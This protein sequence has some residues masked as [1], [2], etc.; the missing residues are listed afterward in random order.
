MWQNILVGLVTSVVLYFTIVNWDKIVDEIAFWARQNNLSGV[1]NVLCT[2]ENIRA[3]FRQL[4]FKLIG[5]NSNDYPEIITK[6]NI[7]IEDLPS[8]FQYIGTKQH[9]ITI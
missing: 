5:K 8:E 4:T 6:K 7:K 2:I 9:S 3:G 1:I